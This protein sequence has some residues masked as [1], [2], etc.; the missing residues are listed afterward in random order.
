MSPT[1]Y[2]YSDGADIE[3]TASSMRLRIEQFVE[4][5]AGR[6]R[7]VDQRHDQNAGPGLPD[8]DFGVNFEDDSLT[9]EEKKDLLLFFQSL[10]AEFDRDFVVGITTPFGQTDDI[11]S[12][13]RNEP[14]EPVIKAL[15]GFQRQEER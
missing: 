15:L 12:V 9:S 14:L 2:I 11:A 6:V 7:V 1:I 3:D 13:S 8:W 10:S 5:Y 4:L